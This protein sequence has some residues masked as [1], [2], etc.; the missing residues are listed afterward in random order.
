MFKWKQPLSEEI[1]KKKYMINE[2]D[3][4]VETIIQNISKE[5][6][7]VEKTKEKQQL[8]QELF[9]TEIINQR[10][11][12]AGRILAHARPNSKQKTYINCYTVGIED[13][14]NGIYDTIK[15]MAL[16]AQSSGG[17]GLNI[18]NIRP[19]GAI[20]SRGGTASG[21]LSF[22]KVI[23]ESAN[24][25]C[26]GGARR[27]ATIIILNVDHPDIEK[28]ITC[29]H[30]DENKAY[31]FMNI[32]VGITDEF[33]N[34]VEQ[35]LNWDLKFDGKIYKT[36]K[37][38][39]LYNLIIEN[40]FK[41]AEPGVLNLS[42]INKEN[43]GYY[44]Y[45][46]NECNPCFTGETMIAVA[47]GRNAVSIKQLADENKEFLI[48]STKYKMK[49]WNRTPEI[50]KAKAFKTG[51]KEVLT[52][53]LSNGSS[54]ECT[55]D[56]LLALPNGTFIQAKDSLGE[57]LQKFYTF[58]NKNNNKSYRHI[59]SITNCHS[60]QCRLIYNYYNKLEQGTVIHHKDHNSINDLID[61]LQ[62]LTKEEHDKLTGEEHKGNN[63]PIFKTNM[64]WTKWDW[65]RKNRFANA[66]KYNW[67]DERLKKELEIYDRENPEPTRDITDKN[68][69][70]NQDV[71]VIDVIRNGKV[72][73]VYDITVEDNHNF[74][75][76]TKTDDDK[77][78]NCSG[79]LVH[80]CGETS[81]PIYNVCDLGSI[82]L[83][84]FVENPFTNEAKIDWERLIKSIHIGVRFLDNVLDATQLPLDK[85]KHNVKKE[86][87]IGLGF[88][89]YA[90]MLIKMKIQYGSEEAIQ[91]TKKLA[92]I[93]RD[94]S[95]KASIEL[96]K[97][98]GSFPHL[99]KEKYLQSNFIKRL[100]EEIKENIKK[101]GIRNINLNC[102][103]PTGTISLSYGNNCSSGIEPV[104]ALSYDRKVRQKDETFITQTVCDEAFLDWQNQFNNEKEIPKYFTT[105]ADLT[106]EQHIAIQSLWQKYIDSSI[107]KTVNLPSGTTIEKYK[108]LFMLAYKSGCKGITFFNPD[109]A[110][111][112]VLSVKK[113]NVK[114]QEDIKENQ[115]PKRPQDL[116]CDIYQIV[117]DHKP[118]LVLLGKLN[119][120]IYEMFLDYNFDENGDKKIDV[121]KAKEGIIRKIKSSQY[122][123]IIK[124]DEGKELTII[125]N[126]A[127]TFDEMAGMISRF[128]SMSLRYGVPYQFIINQMQKTKS[129]NSFTKI[130]SRVLKK[131][132][133]DGEKVKTSDN[134]CPECNT[135]LVFQSGCII[136]PSCGF[137]K[138]N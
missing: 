20:L 77:Y 82:K 8:W 130:V 91:L 74:Y 97:E 95:Y 17:S 120:K 28:F 107:S 54:F 115:A 65:A 55:P 126:I 85:V 59:N 71:Q 117:V 46:I 36:V 80:N 94:E 9:Y 110:L 78:L 35:D 73:P 102:V 87:R 64:E 109:G 13:S 45:N 61:N 37:A 51:E 83:S 62:A 47:D 32:S 123:L 29:K 31:Q 93:F 23:N 76:I 69:Y 101:Y 18:S 1:F 68:I 122:D 14:L 134:K 127:D 41:Y 88:T 58:S 116:P 22:M 15:E 113:E 136:C 112:P 92:K 52:I 16:I 48:Y 42:A 3:K 99:D 111:A 49:K 21:P 19:E 24:T 25:I 39:D 33:M 56:H 2:G 75:I 121:M 53:V 70:M 135:E 96:A 6:S 118:V 124:T 27:S 67:T 26:V 81:M 11:I 40:S 138:C 10:F 7:S 12:P 84:T 98:K 89:A 131:Y 38:K 72:A 100:P 114:Q 132:I 119:S 129:F 79:V 90:D 57:V 125:K 105:V 128:V 60:K 30:G 50:K 34:A 4:D 44:M 63:N 104:F 86:R 133:K 106:A 103:A 66:R 137:S 5:I 43:N 108:D